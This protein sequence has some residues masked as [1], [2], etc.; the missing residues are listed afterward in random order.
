MQSHPRRG[1]AVPGAAA[2]TAGTLVDPHRLA[3]ATDSEL[4]DVFRKVTT[5]PLEVFVNEGGHRVD[6][7]RNLLGTW[8]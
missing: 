3:Q 1:Q 5:L 4:A 7:A 8:A 6:M 2:S